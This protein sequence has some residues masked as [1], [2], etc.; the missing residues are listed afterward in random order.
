MGI[1][2]Q[3]DQDSVAPLSSTAEATCQ[4]DAEGLGVRELR[5]FMKHTE[6]AL[7]MASGLVCRKGEDRSHEDRTG[8]EQEMAVTLNATETGIRKFN[9]GG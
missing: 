5:L 6:K 7:L 1:I 9:R 2:S 8:V 3:R 4:R